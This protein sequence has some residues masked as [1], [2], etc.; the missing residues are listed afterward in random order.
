[1]KDYRI[2]EAAQKYLS[3]SNQDYRE[4]PREDYRIREMTIKYLNGELGNREDY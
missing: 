2:Q 1:M 3:G 4:E